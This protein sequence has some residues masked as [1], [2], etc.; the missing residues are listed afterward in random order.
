ME[1]ILVDFLEF[2]VGLAKLEVFKRAAW[3]NNTRWRGQERNG[4]RID[5]EEL[6]P[7]AW[8]TYFRYFHHRA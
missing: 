3:R 8:R 6:E 5:L 7:E 2:E 4:G 1:H